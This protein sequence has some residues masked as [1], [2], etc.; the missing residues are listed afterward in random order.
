MNRSAL[1]KR[2]LGASFEGYY[3]FVGDLDVALSEVKE[4]AQPKVVGYL[5]AP[6][7]TKKKTHKICVYV[8]CFRVVYAL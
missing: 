8:K 4:H 3:T 7:D 5:F 6:T 2:G 1:E